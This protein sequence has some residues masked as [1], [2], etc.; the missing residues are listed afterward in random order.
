MNPTRQAIF[1]YL[2]RYPCRHVRAI[3]RDLKLKIPTVLWH[4]GKLQEKGFLSSASFKS[5]KVFYPAGLISQSD[6][7]VFALLE[8]NNVRKIC[9][10]LI[11]KG[12]LSQKE[13]IA[14]ADTYQQSA[15]WYLNQLKDFG[16]VETKK[17]GRYTIFS[18]TSRLEEIKEHCTVLWDDFKSDL[19]VRLQKDGVAPKVTRD[20]VRG[21]IIHIDS[22]SKKFSLKIKKV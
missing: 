6:V 9:A 10:A 5:R 21:I 22:G 15:G 12:D 20:D 14:I 11:E 8:N 2:C 18:M 7:A 1:Q 16:I 4:L 13:I 19:L 17:E 3:E